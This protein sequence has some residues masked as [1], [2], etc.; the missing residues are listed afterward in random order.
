VR[1]SVSSPIAEAPRV[2]QI[3]GTFD[4]AEAKASSVTWDVDMPLAERP[5]NIG[6]SSG[7]PAAEGHHRPQGVPS[8]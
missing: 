4:L 3:R 2:A 5:W 1:I 6:Q 7:R 8:R